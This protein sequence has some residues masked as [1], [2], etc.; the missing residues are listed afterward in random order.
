MKKTNRKYHRT[1]ND[2][3]RHF[4]DWYSR[5]RYVSDDLV[6]KINKWA[7]RKYVFNSH[8]RPTI[9]DFERDRKYAHTSSGDFCP[10]NI[11]HDRIERPPI[12][13]ICKICGKTK[14]IQMI[15][16]SVIDYR[17]MKYDGI[18]LRQCWT[19]GDDVAWLTYE[20]F[21]NRYCREYTSKFQLIDI[22]SPTCDDDRCAVLYGMVMEKKVNGDKLISVNKIRRD[23]LC[24]QPSEKKKAILAANYAL[25]TARSF[26]RAAR[27]L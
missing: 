26:E 22:P 11:Y 25:I 24:M 18:T 8:H 14:Y 9:D 1:T 5:R 12:F 19:M 10:I 6:D 16:R 21:K 2:Y 15:C 3:V 13:H 17:S 20:V 7:H 4:I 27:K 23:I